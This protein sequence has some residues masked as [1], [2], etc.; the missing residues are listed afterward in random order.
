MKK[1]Q[2]GSI[3]MDNRFGPSMYIYIMVLMGLVLF[4]H[5]AHA[6][7]VIRTGTCGGTV[8]DGSSASTPCKSV[9]IGADGNVY[10]KNNSKRDG[11]GYTDTGISLKGEDGVDGKDGKDADPSGLS[12]IENKLREVADK[13][14]KLEG[15]A[16]I[17][18]AI[19][20]VKVRTPEPKKGSMGLAL[21]SIDG[22]KSLGG[23][24]R[25]SVDKDM[26]IYANVGVTQDLE[27]GVSVG[28]EWSW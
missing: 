8:V 18:N 10:I 23:S 2:Q 5:M 13:Y 25:Y 19:A 27:A 16:H 21:S 24:I 12:S 14:K 22:K 1:L 17:A 4:T 28:F 15:A 9:A 26:S 7:P 20:A 11:K 6:D 3:P